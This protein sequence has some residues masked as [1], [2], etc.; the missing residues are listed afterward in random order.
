MKKSLK[1]AILLI[2]T[3]I[4]FLPNNQ[5][6][7]CW[8]PGPGG[9]TYQYHFFQFVEYHGSITNSMP[10]INLEGVDERSANLNEWR[11]NFNEFPEIKDIEDILYNATLLELTSIKHHLAKKSLDISVGYFKNT[12]ISFLKNNNDTEFINYLIQVRKCEPYMHEPYRHH[13]KEDSLFMDTKIDEFR[14]MYSKSSSPFFKER[15]AYQ[16]IRLARYSRQYTRAISIYD[17]FMEPT[18]STSMIK[19]WTLDHVAGAY[20][21]RGK[22]SLGKALTATTDRI[23]SGKN[24]VAKGNYLFSIIFDKCPSKRSSSLKSFNIYSND[25]WDS[26]LQLCNNSQEI[27][28]LYAMRATKPKNNIFEEMKV[29]YELDPSSAYLNS[30]MKK[31]FFLIEHQLL[32]KDLN[33]NILT[34]R[35]NTANNKQQ[36]IQTLEQLLDFTGKCINNVLIKDN[37]FWMLAHSYLHILLGNFK[38]AE[39]TLQN[40]KDKNPNRDIQYQMGILELLVDIITTDYLDN[41]IEDKLFLRVKELDNLYLAEFLIKVFGS[42]YDKQGLSS[43]AFLCNN[44]HLDMGYGNNVQTT[45]RFENKDYTA[46]V[47]LNANYSAELIVTILHFMNKKDKTAFE[48]FLITSTLNKQVDW[49]S[50]V[51]FTQDDLLPILGTIAM[52]DHRLDDA[53]MY[54]E[55][56]SD[57]TSLELI[58]NPFEVKIIDS[59]YDCENYGDCYRYPPS[60]IQ[61][62]KLEIAKELKQLLESTKLSHWTPVQAEIYYKIGNYYLNTTY[63]GHSWEMHSMSRTAAFYP[64]SRRYDKDNNFYLDLKTPIKYYDKCIELSEGINNELA[65][66]CAFMAAKCEQYQYTIDP[67]LQESKI[68]TYWEGWEHEYLVLPNYNVYGKYFNILRENFSDTDYYQEAINECKYF[69]Y[70]INVR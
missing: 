55:Q 42:L 15:Y 53:I 1:S 26:V 21:N 43:K 60:E 3:L 16:M 65:A 48:K 46:F 37:E 29:I 47:A 52:R 25:E 38:E 7:A 68:R 24:D 14:N 31:E 40:L 64:L 19:Y 10:G 22:S 62:N 45:N 49:R 36:T 50:T 54:W 51:P 69:R 23:L 5:L 8:Y 6:Y 63:F 2:S 9:Y 67:D 11:N 39:I 4:F 57:K 12:L 18:E 27:I 70:Y 20:I 33:S 34:S 13:E 56:M 41:E 32:G 17:E 28:T 66:E 61:Y 30:L 35:E 58:S 44:S 59:P